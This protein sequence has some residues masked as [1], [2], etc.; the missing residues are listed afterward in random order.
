MGMVCGGPR[1]KIEAKLL[2]GGGGNDLGGG[3]YVINTP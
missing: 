2:G 1:V 3:G